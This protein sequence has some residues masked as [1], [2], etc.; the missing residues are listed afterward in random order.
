MIIGMDFGT[1]NSGM[2]TYDGRV[3]RFVP[4]GTAAPDG[5]I[6][7]TALYVTNDQTVAIGRDAIERYHAH[8]IGRPIRMERSKIGMTSIT[9]PDIGTVLEDIYSERDVLAPGRLFLS[10]KSS[11]SSAAYRG[12]DV[13]SLFYAIEDVVAIYLYLARIRAERVLGQEIRAIVL[14]RPVHFAA[15]SEADAL[16]EQR[17]IE[18]AWRAGYE[19][20]YLH[21]EPVAVAFQYATTLEREEHVLVFDFGGGT[22]DIAAMRLDGRGQHTVLATGGIPI[23]GDVFDQRIV[24]TRLAERL[25]EGSFFGPRNRRRV[26]PSWIYD[27]LANWQTI[28]RLQAIRHQP[29]FNE[30]LATTDQPAKIEALV[31][32]ISQNYGLSLFDAAERAKRALSD[33]IETTITL[34]GPDFAIHE[35]FTRQTFTQIIQQDVRAVDQLIETVVRTAGLT[36]P[37]I[38]RV[39]R[40][41]GSSQIPVFADL[42]RQKFG[43]DRVRAVD[44]FSSVTAGLG[45]IA[46]Q[47]ATDQIQLAAHCRNE[48]APVSEPPDEIPTMR[49]LQPWIAAQEQ[50]VKATSER[51]MTL[52]VLANDGDVR[53]LPLP[54]SWATAGHAMPLPQHADSRRAPKQTTFATLDEPLLLVTTA[55]RFLLTTPRRLLVQ[56]EVGLRVGIIEQFS[57]GERVSALARWNDM[58]QTRWLAVLT[59]EGEMRLLDCG[60]SAEALGRALPLQ[61]D[62][63]PSGAPVEVFAANDGQEVAILTSAARGL[64]VRIDASVVPGFQAIKRDAQETIVRAVPLSDAAPCLLVS[65][66]GA[67]RVIQMADVPLA[68]GRAPKGKMLASRFAVQTAAVLPPDA[69]LWLVTPTSCRPLEP[70]VLAKTVARP[71]K[72]QQID[73]SDGELV[74]GLIAR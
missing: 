28:A 64:R 14:G 57:P 36:L 73:V 10:F 67:L 29:L 17:L 26:A 68:S 53:A 20:V 70:G 74:T 21:Y 52:V 8:T 72:Q 30:L 5:T 61:L 56:H 18:A 54:A 6:T 39:V 27:D 7:R 11:L 66:T 19:T 9:Y 69:S 50:A 48:R 33:A 1:T 63:K 58:R 24:R 16:A 34:T 51:E 23:A 3:I 44:T 38:D 47:I 46:H 12:T 55:Y 13:G 41:G 22:L 35:P 45:V 31:K 43:A 4:F 59:S 15:D 60:K 49:F 2:A 40:T 65:P 25:G 32:I 37:A 71:S 42:L 62:Q